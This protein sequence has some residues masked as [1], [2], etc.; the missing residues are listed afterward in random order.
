MKLSPAPATSVSAAI[1]V[2]FSPGPVSQR[3]IPNIKQNDNREVA[4][5]ISVKLEVELT[6]ITEGNY[7]DEFRIETETDIFRI[8]VAA[9]ILRVK[10]A[11]KIQGYVLN[12]I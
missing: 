11:R 10:S 5:G 4:P 12:H 9:S 7:E 2:L 8:P 1:Q 6:A 3:T